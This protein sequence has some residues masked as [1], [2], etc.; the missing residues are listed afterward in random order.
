MNFLWAMTTFS[1]YDKTYC[2]IEN[3]S[4]LIFN[5]IICIHL[6]NYFILIILRLFT[7]KQFCFIYIIR[8]IN[9]LGNRMIIVY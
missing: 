9:V 1:I 7:I 8:K 4:D 5:Y 2:Y 3:S 6:F